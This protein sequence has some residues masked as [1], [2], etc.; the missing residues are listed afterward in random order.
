MATYNQTYISLKNPALKNMLFPYV[1][2]K[3]ERL[4][5]YSL[6][7]ALLWKSGNYFS[8]EE[9]WDK[10]IEPIIENLNIHPMPPTSPFD[11]AIV[12]IADGCE[13]RDKVWE[14]VQKAYKM[15][16]IKKDHDWYYRKD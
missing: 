9:Y 16:V 3:F 12:K 8:I 11:K 13:E 10:A 14:N 4:S 15:I 1:D 6:W 5:V 2:Y 7:R